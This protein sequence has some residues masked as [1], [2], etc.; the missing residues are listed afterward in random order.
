MKIIHIIIGL[1]IG[2]AEMMLYKLLKATPL[3]SVK[4]HLVIS[5]TPDGALVPSI[6]NLG[7]EVIELNLSKRYPLSFFSTL[8]N[9]RH[10]LINQNPS[11]IQT[12]MYHA[13]I[14]TIL[15][16]LDRRGWIL[17]WNIRHSLDNLTHEKPLT[18]LLIKCGRYFSRVPRK[19]IY[20]STVSALQHEGIG[21]KTNKTLIIPNGFDTKIFQRKPCCHAK[22]RGELGLADDVLLIGNVARYHPIK[23][24]KYLIKAFIDL[25]RQ[26]NSSHTHL[27]LIGKNINCNNIEL[28]TLIPPSMKPFIHL[29]GARQDIPDLLS[30]LDIFVLPSLSEGFP[31]VVGEAML[32]ELP[33]IITDVGDTKYVTGNIAKIVSPGNTLEITEALKHMIQL[34]EE[35]REI[36]GKMGRQRIVDNF[37]ISKIQELY[38]SL[39][40]TKE[41]L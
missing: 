36:L 23:G 7:V 15:S 35:E 24:H 34:P 10:I 33:C 16:I 39:Y 31:N 41:N 1:D 25:L 30:G 11:I 37:S 8:F 18:K 19:I 5:L 17:I 3:D 20:N 4:N 26:G 38:D 27:V 6:Q 40:K 14:I 28:T 9:L 21:Y 22:L 29:L 12:W 13:N 2:G 32:C